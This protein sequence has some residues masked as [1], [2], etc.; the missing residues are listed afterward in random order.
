MIKRLSIVFLLIFVLIFH[1]FSQ[2]INNNATDSFLLKLLNSGDTTINELLSNQSKY[3]F[4]LSYTRV[5]KNKS[6]EWFEEHSLN[7][8]KFYFNPASSIKLP[9]LLL[10]LEKLTYL[11]EKGIDLDT[12]ISVH[13]CSCDFDTDGYVAKSKNPTMRQF[14]RELIIMS[15]NDA[16]NLLVD[17]VGYEY[18]NKR[19]RQ[20]GYD[21]FILKRRFTS[22]CSTDQNKWY[23]GLRFYDSANNLLY[24]QECDTS[25][26]IYFIDST[27]YILTAGTAHLENGIL[28]EGP[29]DFSN[30]NYLN[31]NQMNHFFKEIFIPEK[32]NKNFKID[33]VYKVALFDALKDYPYSLTNSGYDLSNIQDWHYKFFI[34]SS[35]MNTTNMRLKIYNKVGMAGGFVSDFSHIVDESSGIEYFLSA[36]MLAKKD[37]VI[38]R[39]KNNYDDFGIPVFRKIG[40][41]I[42]NYELNHKLNQKN[43]RD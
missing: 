20:L 19:Y 26:E 22:N 39:G 13:T 42:Y 25:K 11:K 17:F 36:T 16:Y 37:D 4:Q 32:F 21:G 10:A 6:K 34:D 12:R 15:D 33:S 29:K 2:S 9:L 41:I 40:A 14:I 35:V 23:G 24:V 5:L 27:K 31:F 3:Q 38:N 28:V 7:E 1:S 43:K 18:F 8:N 30:N